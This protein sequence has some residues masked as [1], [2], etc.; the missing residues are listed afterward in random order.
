MERQPGSGADYMSFKD[1]GEK[2]IP[3]RVETPEEAEL[4][5]RAAARHKAKEAKAAKWEEHRA[6]KKEPHS[7]GAP[8]GEPPE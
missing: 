7:G 1:L 2:N 8:R 5:A 6:A 3:P 4:R